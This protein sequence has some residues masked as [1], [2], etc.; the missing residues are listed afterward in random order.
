MK[1]NFAVKIT[2]DKALI[3]N[4]SN[5]TLKIKKI[6]LVYETTVT[7]IDEKIGL[8][9]ITDEQNIEIELKPNSNIEVSL[10]IPT[11]KRIGVIYVKGDQT[12]REDIEV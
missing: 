5:S 1:R 6:Y 12:L 9:T 4:I 8:R 11:L 10:L 7:T 3:S 2:G